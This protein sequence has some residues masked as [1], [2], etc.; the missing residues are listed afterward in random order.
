MQCKYIRGI[1]PMPLLVR[2]LFLVMLLLCTACGKKGP[3]IAPDGYAPPPVSALEVVQQGERFRISWQAPEQESAG[4]SS[5][6]AGFRLYRREIRTPADECL[7]CGVEDLLI[8]SVEL[9]YL[10]D[11]VR[12]GNLFVLFDGDVWV[13]KSYLYLV[14]A[15]EKG[16]GENRD[17]RRVKRK[18]VIPPPAPVATGGEVPAGIMLEWPDVVVTP[19]TLTGYNIYRQRP[20]EP[21][22]LRPLTKA[23]VTETRYEDLRMEPGTVYRYTLR[24]VARVDGET[25]ESD[26]SPQVEG[27]FILP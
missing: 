3:L 12:L 20:A 26:P 23:P 24:T 7:T 10:K 1:R 8:R 6:L 25:V 9:E 19:G 5:L 4:G 16:G 2:L 13:G 18:K 17:S 15:F 21:F 14:T 11:T 22:V 27:K